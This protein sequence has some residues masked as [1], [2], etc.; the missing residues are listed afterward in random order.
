MTEFPRFHG[1]LLDGLKTWCSPTSSSSFA[2]ASNDSHALSWAEPS[3]I[4]EARL[5]ASA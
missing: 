4:H 3:P 5:P 1:Y 2:A